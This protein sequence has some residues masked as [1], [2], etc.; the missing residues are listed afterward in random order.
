VANAAIN[1]QPVFSTRI[2]AAAWEDGV[3]YIKFPDGAE[4]QYAGVDREIFDT[5]MS[6]P[7]AGAYFNNVVKRIYGGSASPVS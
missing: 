2:D 3:L 7:S 1:W 6:V 4:W 5:L